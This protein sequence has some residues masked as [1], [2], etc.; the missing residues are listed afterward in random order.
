[1]ASIVRDGRRQAVTNPLLPPAGTPLCRFDE[2]DDYAGREFVFGQGPG[3]LDMFVVRRGNDVFGYLNACPH[4]S[5]PLNWMAN[6]FFNPSRTLLQC[7]THGARFRINDGV[8]ISG[9]CKG[10]ALIPVPIRMEDGNVV[11]AEE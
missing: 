11:I 5:A 1:M 4:T 7:A 9:P 3:A 10:D 8:C 6:K 2:I